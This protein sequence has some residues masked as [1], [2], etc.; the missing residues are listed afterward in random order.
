VRSNRPDGTAEVAPIYSI[1]ISP[2][3]GLKIYELPLPLYRTIISINYFNE[4]EDFP[5]ANKIEISSRQ[6]NK[7]AF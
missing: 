6:S 4:Q 1:P 2:T 7:D 3:I 5:L